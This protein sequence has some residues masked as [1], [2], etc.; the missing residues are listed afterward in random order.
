M[1]GKKKNLRN[2]GLGVPSTVRVGWSG[3]QIPIKT[4]KQNENVHWMV[5][6]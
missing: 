2:S 3:G 4:G 1:V 5:G 6:S